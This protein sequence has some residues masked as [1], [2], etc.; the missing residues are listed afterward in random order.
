M[1][2]IEG[3][4]GDAVLEAARALAVVAKDMQ[5]VARSH[6]PEMPEGDWVRQFCTVRVQTA[7]SGGHTWAGAR[8]AEMFGVN[9]TLILA[10]S[11]RQS[12]MLIDKVDGPPMWWR[13]LSGDPLWVADRLPVT[14]HAK[15]VIVVIVDYAQGLTRKQMELTYKMCEYLS[16]N[17]PHFMLF[18]LE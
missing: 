7:R 18:L 14:P 10:P 11:D 4:F 15:N 17:S 5:D 1:E 9:N 12:Q 2:K 13:N 16:Q 8:L 3:R 6:R